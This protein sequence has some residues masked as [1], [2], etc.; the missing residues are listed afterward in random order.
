[1][2][3]RLLANFPYALLGNPPKLGEFKTTPEFLL[4]FESSVFVNRKKSRKAATA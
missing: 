1:M 2:T 4:G 3:H